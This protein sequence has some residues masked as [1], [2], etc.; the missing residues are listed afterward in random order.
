MAR[1]R[2]EAFN[3]IPQHQKIYDQVYRE[4][5]ILY[6]Y[7]GRGANDVMKHLKHLRETI[8][9]HPHTEER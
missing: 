3:P 7:C 9:A 4:Y 8:L 5:S 2:E 6:D 1:L